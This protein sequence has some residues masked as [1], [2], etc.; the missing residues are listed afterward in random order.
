MIYIA[1]NN[2]T[3]KFEG[4]LIHYKK[5]END[6]PAG[7]LDHVGTCKRKAKKKTSTKSKT[8]KK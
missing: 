2:G 1:E 7:S 3:T 8:S 5:G 4:K 6:V